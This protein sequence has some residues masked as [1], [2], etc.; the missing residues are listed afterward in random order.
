MNFDGEDY[1]TGEE[2]QTL[3]AASTSAEDFK[4]K[5]KDRF[6]TDI[7]ADLVHR[8]Q[9]GLEAQPLHGLG[10]ATPRPEN[11][12]S[13]TFS[14][15]TPDSIIGSMDRTLILMDSAQGTRPGEFLDIRHQ[16]VPIRGLLLDPLPTVM[17]RPHLKIGPR[18]VPYL[19]P[20]G[21]RAVIDHSLRLC[22][23]SCTPCHTGD[24]MHGYK[25]ILKTR[26]AKCFRSVIRR[27]L[28]ALENRTS[29]S[30]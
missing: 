12:Q 7:D 30:M 25:S 5:A 10:Q 23:C 14:E 16:N 11:L 21:P 4:A 24:P 18:S 8:I 26:Y 19:R 9:K 20:Y 29:S 1:S 2:V 17:W 28:A 15:L 13:L 22:T 3:L 27:T 6:L